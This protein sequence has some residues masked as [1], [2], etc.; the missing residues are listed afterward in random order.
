M[1]ILHLNCANYGSTGKIIREIATYTKEKGH[2]SFLCCGKVKHVND[3][4]QTYK[5]SLSRQTSVIKWLQRPFGYQYGFSPYSTAKILRF[6]RTIQPD[7]IHLHSANRYMVNL[8]RLFRFIGKHRIPLV[9]TNHAEFYYTGNCSYAF[10][11][12]K[13]KTGCGKC[14]RLR[15]ATGSIGF[16]MTKKAWKRMKQSMESVSYATMVSVS[17]W[18]KSRAS[19]APISKDL[20]QVLVLNGIDINTFQPRD[21]TALRKKLNIPDNKKII[22][23][24]TSHFSKEDRLKGGKYIIELANR[25]K[26]RDVVFLV[27]CSG[28]KE[29][30]LPRN[31]RLIGNVHDQELLA[32]YYSMSDLSVIVS[33]KETYSMPVAESLSCGTPVV[34]FMAGG[35][36]TIAVKEYSDFVS[37]GDMDALEKTVLDWLFSRESLHKETISQTSRTVY[38][39]KE[40]ARKYYEIYQRITS[41]KPDTEHS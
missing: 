28:W 38:S 33:Q 31:I 17:P 29:C 22:L 10:D 30:E 24:V 8:Y 3:G 25:L 9:I 7:I 2:E 21:G 39:S 5:T 40:M 6:I 15:E 20:K 26:D 37:Y 19:T 36:E 1:K 35:P 41:E 4:I 18:V 12:I 27:I 14:P 32:C 34:G 16:D 11:C 13:Y 23:H